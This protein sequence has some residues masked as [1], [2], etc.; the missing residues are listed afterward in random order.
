MMGGTCPDCGT[1]WNESD[2]ATS[3][4]SL[5]Q[6]VGTCPICGDDFTMTP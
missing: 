5:G 2:V 1:F 4:N 6:P 3:W